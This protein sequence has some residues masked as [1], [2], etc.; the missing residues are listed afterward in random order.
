MTSG[1]AMEI[2]PHT[3]GTARVAARGW[4]WTRIGSV[5]YG[6][7]RRVRLT[8]GAP[9]APNV[10]TLLEP[11]DRLRDLG[12]PRAAHKVSAAW[13]RRW[14][15]TWPSVAWP[16]L[17]VAA[18]VDLPV[19]LLPH[20]LSPALAVTRG[21]GTRLLLADAVGQGKTIEAGFLLREL[22]ARGAADRVLILTPLTLRDQWRSEL[23]VRCRL[24]AD[25]VDRASLRAR[26]RRTLAGLSPFQAPGVVLM[27]IDLAKQPD[28]LAR[29]V[30]QCWDVL[31]I[32]EAHG[33]SGDS[34]RAAAAEA[35]GARARLVVL[36]TATPHAGDTT[37]FGRLCAIGRFD[38]DPPPLWF[39]H[40]PGRSG[41][42]D[43]P[44]RCD[45]SPPRSVEE[46]SCASA[47]GAYLRRL[48]RAASPA[49][50]LIA[51]VLRKRWLSSPAALA[52]SL[53]HRMAW[54]E[55]PD[56]RIGQPCLPFDDEEAEPADAE[57]PAVLREGGLADLRAEA[58]LLAAA[59][60]AAEQA[61]ASWA[62]VR[63]LRRL[64][65]RTREQVLVF[66]EYRDTLL[67]LATAISAESSVVTLHGG[68]S[69]GVRAAALA[70]FASGDA[71]VLLATD[72]AAEGV[73]LQQAC[74]LVVHVELPWSPARLEQ[75]NG[76]VD[77]LG[78]RRRVH[79]WRLLGDPRHESRIVA[80]LAGRLARMRAAGIDP[81]TLDAPLTSLAHEP[82]EPDQALV[83]PATQGDA[84]Q[85]AEQLSRLRALVQSC[86]RSQVNHLAGPAGS[87]LPWRRA[88]PCPGGLPPGATILCLVSASTR[89]SR[90]MLVPMHVRLTKHPPARPSRWL[91][92]VARAAV[93]AA[94]ATPQTAALT[95]ALRARE[96]A[97]LRDAK[98]EQVRVAGRWQGS[99]FERRTARIVE[100][101]RAGAAWRTGDH[102][103]RLH[104]LD[105]T[106]GRPVAVAVLALLVG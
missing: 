96:H 30:H 65:R 55:R 75:R 79:V 94:I 83:L 5:Q 95:K 58:A 34:A 42:H 92:A 49:A 15:A 73:N 86:T 100:A 71:R 36:L 98:A 28:I 99:L 74:R 85:V 78:Q 20:Q 32:D 56:A 102:Q 63:A 60:V 66:T 9:D 38:G 19:A 87:A 45:I 76:R 84:S 7:V 97:L 106:A 68:C 35:L 77:R 104:E 17:Q 43:W 50:P 46:R 27:S 22:A 62:K 10:D 64:L 13:L 52:A 82:A 69:H 91:P 48:E 12:S 29:L 8:A 61:A 93:A 41:V 18:P 51:L 81:G 54:L 72:V 37:A 59:H 67:A 1:G 44:K 88:R 89:G 53:R 80:A 11:F 31:V 105:E 57:Q 70:Q 101:A 6:A 21:A 3:D 23:A 39:R 25:I 26:E 33:V 47:L 103:R 2:P 24:D 90:P 4:T 40:R 16:V 14:V